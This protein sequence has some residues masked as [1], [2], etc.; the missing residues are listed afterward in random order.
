MTIDIGTLGI[1]ILSIPAIIMVGAFLVQL[2]SDVGGA[3]LVICLVGGLGLII[4]SANIKTPV[5]NTNKVE[6]QR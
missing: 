3:F 2:M 6:V 4:Y 1:I 5:D